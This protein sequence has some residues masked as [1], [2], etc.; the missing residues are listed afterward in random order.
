MNQQIT[1]GVRSSRNPEYNSHAV[2]ERLRP[3]AL[4]IGDRS[5][6][7]LCR[8]ELAS[9][10]ALHD[11]EPLRSGLENHPATHLGADEGSP[12]ERHISQVV[13]AMVVRVHDV[14]DWL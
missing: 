4:G 5:G 2:D 10:S 14:R 3:R 9:D 13:I 6:Q 12:L 1:D 8:G 11:P 7:R